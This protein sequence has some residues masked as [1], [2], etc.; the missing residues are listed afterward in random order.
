MAPHTRKIKLNHKLPNIHY[1][2]KG[3]QFFVPSILCCYFLITLQTCLCVLDLYFT[4]KK[5]QT[6]TK[7]MKKFFLSFFPTIFFMYNPAVKKK[8][9]W[10]NGLWKR[11][12]QTDL[13]CNIDFIAPITSHASCLAHLG[14]LSFWMSLLTEWSF[15]IQRWWLMMTVSF[16]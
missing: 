1:T 10:D 8:M 11:Q 6:K 3:V 5:F 13:L 14:R 12:Q 2:H 16:V 9:K 15:T 7:T 4:C